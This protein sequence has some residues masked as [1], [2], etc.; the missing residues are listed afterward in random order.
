MEL[1]VQWVAL[2]CRY[3][4]FMEEHLRDQHGH[5]VLP[6]Q[7]EAL[8]REVL[9]LGVMPSMRAL[10]TAGPALRGSGIAAYNCSYL[11]IDAPEAFH[12]VLYILMHGTG[13][14]FSVERQFTGVTPF[15]PSPLPALPE[16]GQH[17]LMPVDDLLR[18]EQRGRGSVTAKSRQVLRQGCRGVSCGAIRLSGL[19]AGRGVRVALHRLMDDGEAHTLLCCLLC[20]L[21]C[22]SFERLCRS[23]FSVGHQ[24]NC[25]RLVHTTHAWMSVQPY[26][27]IG[28]RS[29]H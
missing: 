14:G 9:S 22:G 6:A 29:A 26:V 27:R 21:L 17:T 16:L 25:R 12:E 7:R 11:P 3:F 28:V 4:D 13:V 20:G 1:H 15:T 5:R 18:W 2:A 8:E 19:A 24:T 23:P 10:M